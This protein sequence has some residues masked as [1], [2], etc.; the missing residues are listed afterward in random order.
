MGS[1]YL[2]TQNRLNRQVAIKVLPQ[3]LS[4][5]PEVRAGT[6]GLLGHIAER[7]ADTRAVAIVGVVCVMS[8]LS[9]A[10]PH[11]PETA[12]LLASPL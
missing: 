1:V 9:L 11:A 2:A 7:V 8:A 5:Q 10:A 4:A 12:T 3:H 6:A